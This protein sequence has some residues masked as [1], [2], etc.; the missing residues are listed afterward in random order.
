MSDGF[1]DTEQDGKIGAAFGSLVESEKNFL[2]ER[3]RVPKNS[4][5]EAVSLM[6][7]WEDYA[8]MRG[9]LHYSSNTGA[10]R[11]HILNLGRW[12]E[13]AISYDLLRERLDEG[14]D[15]E[16]I[17]IYFAVGGHGN[18]MKNI[19]DFVG[20][21]LIKKFG[22]RADSFRMIITG[23]GKIDFE[24]ASC[25]SCPEAKRNCGIRE[26][27]NCYDAGGYEEVAAEKERDRRDYMKIAREYDLNLGL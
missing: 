17:H 24:R 20:A 11:R 7:G 19:N 12:L 13:G 16:R 14:E 25:G 3:K 26:R 15:V 4:R 23:D 27:C 2:S 9:G 5:A 22:E 10:A 18:M 1:S 8:M 21:A 6:R